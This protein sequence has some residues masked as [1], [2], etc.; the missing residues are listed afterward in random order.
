VNLTPTEWIFFIPIVNSIIILTIA[1]Y[2]WFVSR[3]YRSEVKY[4]RDEMKTVSIT[5]DYM[6]EERMSI[7]KDMGE[8]LAIVR[9]M[10]MMTIEDRQTLN[11]LFE[12]HDVKDETGRYIWYDQSSITESMAILTQCVERITSVMETEDR[13]GDG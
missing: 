7:M 13:E 1:I 11:E 2:V 10:N 5:E 3:H 9:A 6:R 8:L 12:M 4:L